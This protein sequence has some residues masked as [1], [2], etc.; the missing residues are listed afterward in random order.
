MPVYLLG[1]KGDEVRRI[2][3]KLQALGMY[4]GPI[5]GDFGG[6]TATAV[7]KFQQTAQLAV[8]GQVGPITWAALFKAAIPI[9]EMRS[10]PLDYRCLA[11]TG[12][13]ETGAA[14]PTALPDSPAISTARGSVSA[15]ASGTSARDRCS[16]CCGECAP[17]TR[18]CSHPVLRQLCAADRGAERLERELMAF[19]RTIQHPIKKTVNASRGAA[20]S[21]RLGGPKNSSG[22]SRRGQ[23]PV[24]V[25]A[26]VVLRLR[27]LVGA[28]RGPHVRHQG[29]ER[30]HHWQ[31]YGTDHD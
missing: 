23:R 14:F 4:Q 12:S 2:Q 20:C 5:D 8:D 25:G 18:R 11:L 6:G 10:R 31:C 27:P 26:A 15:S 22:S 7:R 3:V 30:Q 13:F 21:S 19:A 17:I 16:R 1:S 9:P 28:R 29:A 24:P